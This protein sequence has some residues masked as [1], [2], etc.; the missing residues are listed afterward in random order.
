VHMVLAECSLS[1]VTAPWQLL[2]LAC[3][4]PL[5]GSSGLSGSGWG[6]N[7]EIPDIRFFQTIE[8]N[9]TELLLICVDWSTLAVD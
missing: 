9:S 8:A 2:L 1:A 6:E 4:R 7:L 5:R 3:R